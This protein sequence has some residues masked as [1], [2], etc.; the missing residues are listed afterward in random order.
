MKRTI[1]IK[2][3]K[4]TVILDASQWLTLD[5]I[6]NNNAAKWINDKVK[7]RPK[8]YT[9]NSW[10]KHQLFMQSIVPDMQKLGRL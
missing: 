7:D 10:I 1:N 6:S 2:G 8:S 9:I 4:A 3:K 5:S